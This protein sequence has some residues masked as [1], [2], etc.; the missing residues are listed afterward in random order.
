MLTDEKVNSLDNRNKNK[1]D[2]KKRVN[3][4][5]VAIVILVILFL[6]LPTIYCIILGLQVNRLEQQVSE[7]LEIHKNYGITMDDSKNERYAYA[8]E[9]DTT[10]KMKEEPEEANDIHV[11]LGAE[12]ALA[13]D[14][15]SIEV[16]PEEPLINRVD[17]MDKTPDKE[18][19]EKI[20][21]TDGIEDKKNTED[22]KSTE[23]IK[24][25][26]DLKNTED[27]DK[28]KKSEEKLGK[29]AGKK[30]YIT[31]DDG[32]SVYTNEILDILEQYNVKATFFVT[33]KE[34]DYSKEIY[35]R[36]VNDGHTLGMHSYSHV[37]KK[38]YNSVEDFD[39]DF[40]KLRKLLYDT[41]GYMPSIFRFPGGSDNLVNKNGM[42]DFIRYLNKASIVYFD[43]NVVNGDATGYQY[44]KKQLIRNVLSGVD[45]KK[46]SIVLMHDSPTKGK[47]VESLPDLLEKLIKEDA[48]ILP[49]NE[50][51][52]PIQMIKA[53]TIE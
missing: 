23:D 6:V 15:A 51:V 38:I 11:I 10:E 9:K 13:S 7:L 5:K 17:S 40:T 12:D 41:T 32:P 44:T 28:I 29:Y 31:F 36:I 34:D 52:S 47:T 19:I 16:T 20:E 43:W 30:V 46:V 3:R 39:K 48:E 35:R 4:I 8:A 50:E 26:E 37:Y 21:N 1:T 45:N 49:L 2:R 25:I 22:I 42:E 53:D 14:E 33:G 24:N 27:I 18:E